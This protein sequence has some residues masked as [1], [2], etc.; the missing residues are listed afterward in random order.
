MKRH[1][2]AVAAVAL[3]LAASTAACVRRAPVASTP[4]PARP[5][6]SGTAPRQVANLGVQTRAPSAEEA[7]SMKLP[8]GVRPQGQVVETVEE[9]GAAEKA[10]IK[11]GDVLLSLRGTPLHSRDVLEDL[12]AVTPPG[13][14][15]DVGIR[16]KST[17]ASET[18]RVSP[19]AG[20]SP[21]RGI[22]WDYA[23]LEQIEEAIAQARR[24]G[25][26]VLI[27]ISGA[28]T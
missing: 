2:L 28:E 24:E 14:V 17:G 11:P 26:P 9:G 23:G 13:S 10:G 27:G 19:A 21:R 25:K 3:G 4:A 22:A 20:P 8:R 6:P 18:L 5:A 1:R 7:E 12:E 16:R 15:V